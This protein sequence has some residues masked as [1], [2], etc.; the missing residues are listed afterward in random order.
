MVT[1]YLEQLA[2]LGFIRNPSP[3]FGA[4]GGMWIGYT[5]TD[6]GLAL[7]KSEQELR[8]AAADL[9]A[10]AKH[11]VSESVRELLRECERARINENYKEELL[12]TLEEIAT[13]FDE[14][15]FIAAIGSLKYR[16]ECLFREFR[17]DSIPQLFES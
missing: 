11:E 12:R 8:I 16:F 6:R 7:S 13:C 5:L 9:T 15:C 3:M 14:G 1:T 17:T 10:D 2:L 4:D